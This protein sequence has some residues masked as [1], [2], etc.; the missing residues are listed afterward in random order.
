[1]IQTD[2]IFFP[3]LVTNIVNFLNHNQREEIIN[4]S[5]NINLKRQFR[6]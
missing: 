6:W 1:M 3:I 5:K 2:I 4:F